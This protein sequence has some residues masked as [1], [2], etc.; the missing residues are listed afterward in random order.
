MEG[1][2]MGF[3]RLFLCSLFVAVLCGSSTNAAQKSPNFILILTDD[4]SWVGSSLLIDPDDNRTRSDYYQT[5]N[6]ERL[7]SRSMRFTQG[8]APAPYCCPT[9]RSI[10]I[11]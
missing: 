5:P 10:Q 11:G 7:A 3:S 2:R 6:I 4:Q 8:Y 9:R 1:N